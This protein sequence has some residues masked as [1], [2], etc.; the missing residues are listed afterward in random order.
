[1]L[2]VVYRWLLVKYCV[3]LAARSSLRDARCR[4]VLVVGCV[5]VVVFCLVRVDYRSLLLFAC[6]FVM[7]CSSFVRCWL[8]VLGCCELFVGC[9]LAHVGVGVMCFLFVLGYA[10]LLCNLLFLVC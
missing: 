8:L 9:C 4:V 3:L 5:R 1:M 6:L 2:L 10:L 7:C